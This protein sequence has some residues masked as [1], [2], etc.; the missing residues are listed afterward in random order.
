M[1]NTKIAKTLDTVHTH[2]HTQCFYKKDL[3]D[4]LERERDTF[5]GQR[6]IIVQ[7]SDTSHFRGYLEWNKIKK[8]MRTH[9]TC[10]LF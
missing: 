1:K 6:D 5:R 10:M 7:Q 3:L 4:S 8:N 2:T 9:G